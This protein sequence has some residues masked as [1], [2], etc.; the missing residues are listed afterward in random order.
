MSPEPA[1]RLNKWIFLAVDAAL[2]LTAFLIVHFARDAYAPLTFISAVLCVVVAAAVG[3]TPFLTDYVAD[4]ADDSRAEAQRVVLQT[5]RLQAAVDS[6]A[7]ATAHIKVIEESVQKSAHHA[8]KLPYRLGEKIEEF[9]ELLSARENNERDALTEEITELRA[10]N[11]AQLKAV[12]AQV[13][14]TVME[15]KK[16]EAATQQRLVD[17]RQAL[18]KAVSMPTSVAPAAPVAETPS[19]PPATEVLFGEPEFVAPTVAAI[20]TTEETKPKKSRAP[21]K[22]KAEEM[23]AALETESSESPAPSAEVEVVPEEAA[24]VAESLPGDEQASKGEDDLVAAEESAPSVSEV[25]ESVVAPEPES[26]ASSDGATRL[27]VTAYI[28]IGNKLYIR[29]DG[30]GLSWD[31]GV[32][33]QFVSIGKWGWSSQEAAGPVRCRLYKNDTQASNEGEIVLEPARHT[34]LAAQF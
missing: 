33:M 1:P 19:V 14:A 29:G 16:L 31:K 23:P 24:P 15:W 28:G 34:E 21:R 20:E 10:A 26:S 27:L 8:E 9:N 6:L 3:L 18:E 4:V 17:V 11:L 13:E 7:K 25:S 12:A 32:P 30:P 22:P 2:L 5:Q